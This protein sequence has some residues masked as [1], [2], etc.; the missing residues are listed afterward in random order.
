[1]LYFLRRVKKGRNTQIQ[2]KNFYLI[3]INNSAYPGK[4]LHGYL[5]Q[6]E[7]QFM[8]KINAVLQD[9]W[10][11]N[12]PTEKFIQMRKLCILPNPVYDAAI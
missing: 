7:N 12:L 5:I 3:F 9:N 4:I 10:L 1:M 11:L 6:A 2:Y 8:M